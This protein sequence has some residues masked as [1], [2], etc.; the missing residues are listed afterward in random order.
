MIMLMTLM[1]TALI[2]LIGLF[3][4]SQAGARPNNNILLG[5]NLPAHALKDE[6]VSDI[7]KKYRRAYTR[8]TL[9]FLLLMIPML[10]MVEHS[11]LLMAYFFLWLL[12]LLFLKIQTI[13]QYASRMYALKTEKKWQMDT[14]HIIFVDTAVSRL[15]DT[16]MLSKVWFL[17]P[18]IM[19]FLPVIGNI[20][21]QQET[22]SWPVII[23]GFVILV[24]FFSIYLAIG[25]MRTK[26]YSENTEINLHLNQ[27]FKGQWSKCIIFLTIFSSFFYVVLFYLTEIQ[28][29]TAVQIATM[30]YSLMLLILPVM[31]H[32]KIRGERNRL[33]GPE[34][35]VVERD[36]DRYW[37]GGLIYNNPNDSSFLVEKRVGIGMTMNVG[38][39][40]GKLVVAGMVLL[41]VGSIALTIWA[42][43]GTS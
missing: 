11:S 30:M 7:V 27:V 31:S 5:V 8:Y 17:L 2:A 25:K 32:H 36:D 28:N 18:L 15:K 9:I 35:E 39:L 40:A 10:F 6:A 20:F 21:E 26:T 3:L 29:T 33:L 12:L 42:M 16:F 13:T 41:L 24:L 37:I 23:T 38:T 4:S 43:L 34:S 1:G 14:P 19:L 22:L